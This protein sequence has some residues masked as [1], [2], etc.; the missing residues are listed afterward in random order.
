VA[1]R[2]T[3]PAAEAIQLEILRKMSPAE[4]LL[5]ALD[6]SEFVRKLARAH[7]HEEHPDWPEARVTRELLR[8]ALFPLELP[9]ELR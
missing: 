4:R 2:D 7:I 5:L 9:P 1:A 3:S 8:R 6:M